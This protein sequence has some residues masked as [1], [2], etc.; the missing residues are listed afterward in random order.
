VR[1]GVLLDHLD[2]TPGG[3]EA[4]T[5]ALL[6]RCVAQGE[7]AVVA[8]LSGSAPEGVETLV[9]RAP[10]RRPDRDRVFAV[11]GE[12]ALRAA[13]CD[14]V[15]AIR[16]A[17]SCDVYLPHGGLVED[18]RA[19]RDE[20]RGG[21][22][23]L[24]RLGRRLSR[25]QAFFREAESALLGAREGPRVIAVSEALRERIRA[26]YPQAAGR[27]VTIPN[28]VDAE[29]FRR[30]RFA[31]AGAALRHTLG[32][33]GHLVALLLAHHPLL[34]GAE[35]ALRALARPEV[36]EL[37]R[38]L[39]LLVAGGPLPARLGRLARTLGVAGAVHARPA[40]ADPRP[41]Y[42]AADLLLHPTWYDPCSLVCLEAL[43]MGLPVVTTPRNGV[44]EIL[45]QRGG[46]VV[47][48]PGNPQA[49]A[50]ALRV[51]AD[52]DLR[53]LTADDAR[54]LALRNREA[55]RLDEVLEVCRGAA[56]GGAV[57]AGGGGGRG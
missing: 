44:R 47:E 28:G 40:V 33:D 9:V 16:H 18:A 11:E 54:Y 7:E 8:T 29:R 57:A 10:R 36:R 3:A 42:A 26:R 25:K 50:V 13:G 14:V 51:L 24:A 17:L 15:F 38:P 1:L 6:R 53:A 46:I 5:R 12:R 41:L 21:V 4:H 49:L 31:E 45:G 35:T 19:A 23:L 20:A 39:A 34:K 52:D 56:V 27:T 37:P 2:G 22:G 55:T 30:E 48:E 43:A 32:L